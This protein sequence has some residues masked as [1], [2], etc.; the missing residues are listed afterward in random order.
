M[1]RIAAA[2][3]VIALPVA[4]AAQ[5]TLTPRSVFE[6]TIA[7]TAANG[8]TQPVHVVVQSWEIPKENG[9]TYELPLKGFYLAHLESG[10][11]STTIDGETIEREPG[12][13][14]TVKTG[15]T[16][17]VKVLGEFAVIETT[18]PTKQ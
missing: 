2:C 13:F 3:I 17:Q 11:I 7:T 18:M 1:T 12:A 6:D 4:A 8:A 10:D 15:A 5:T 14:W 16:M 9:T